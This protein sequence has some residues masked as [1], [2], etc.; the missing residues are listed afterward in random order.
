M[1]TLRDCY[2]G[3]VNGEISIGTP[4][5]QLEELYGEDLHYE[6]MDDEYYVKDAE[7]S[8]KLKYPDSTVEHIILRN[9][10]QAKLFVDWAR[11]EL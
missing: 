2:A 3:K 5:A 4:L 7:L 6:P 9:S 1:M 8:F 11:E 10:V